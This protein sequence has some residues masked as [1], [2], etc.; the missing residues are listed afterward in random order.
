MRSVA[1]TQ[2]QEI[3]EFPGQM[4]A[5]QHLWRCFHSLAEPPLA[6]RLADRDLD[7]GEQRQAQG[8][9]IDVGRHAPDHP[10][11]A[12]ALQPVI[13][14]RGREAGGGADLGGGTYVGYEM[15]IE[16]QNQTGTLTNA[17]F[18]LVV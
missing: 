2:L 3:G 15:A 14:R 5:L 9:R 10:L 18:L 12:Q 1:Q 17:N 8:R 7:K 6:V 16:M 4:M 13:D 11:R